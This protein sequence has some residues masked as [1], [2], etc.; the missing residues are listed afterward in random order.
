MEREKVWFEH[1]GNIYEATALN[2]YTI[3]DTVYRNVHLDMGG[4]MSVR[5]SELYTSREECLKAS[6]ERDEKRRR[7]LLDKIQ[8]PEQ[9]IDFCLSHQIYGEDIDYPA[10]KSV[11]EAAA[12]LGMKIKTK[13]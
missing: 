9:L 2:T 1:W 4:T 13:Q 7:E 6:K 3:N 8:T 10:R 12:K 11:I 5:Q